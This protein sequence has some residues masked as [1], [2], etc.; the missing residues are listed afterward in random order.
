MKDSVLSFVSQIKRFDENVLNPQQDRPTE[1]RPH[2]VSPVGYA[3]Y[4]IG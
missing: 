4:P 1:G 3:N 2:L